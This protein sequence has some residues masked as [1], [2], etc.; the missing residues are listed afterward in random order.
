MPENTCPNCGTLR[1]LGLECQKCGVIY[2][3]AEQKAY[4]QKKDRQS[5]GPGAS[6]AGNRS[7]PFERKTTSEYRVDCSACKLEDGMERKTLARFPPILRF[8]GCIIVTP[9]AIGMALSAHAFLS[10]FFSTNQA[11]A[12][13]LFISFVLFCISTVSGLLGWILLMRKNAWVCRRCGY[14][15]ERA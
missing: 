1:N 12:A 2:A 13:G 9:S 7:G 5:G 10:S 6:P 11:A 3:K 15:L 4:Q 8:I 14:M